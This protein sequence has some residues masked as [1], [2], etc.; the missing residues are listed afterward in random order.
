ME[1]LASHPASSQRDACRRR[2]SHC[3]AA[4]ALWA[5][6]G[7]ASAGPTIAF[8][9]EGFVTFGYAFQLWAREQSFTSSTDNGRATDIYFRRNRLLFSGQ[10]SDIYGFYVQLEAGNDDR[11]G[12]T[13]KPVFYRDAYITADYSDALRF[14]A[15]RFKSTFSR[16]NLEACLEPLTADRAEVISYAPFGAQGGTRD[17]GFALWGNLADAKVQYRLM[18][19]DGRQ[20]DEVARKSLRVTA[21]AHVSLLDPEADYGYKATY[22]GTRRVLTLGAAVDYQ[23]KVAYA[24]FPARTDAKDY[25]AWTVDAF[26][27]YPTTAGTFTLSAALFDYSTGNAINQA[28][29]PLLPV[30]SELKAAYLKGAYLFPQRVGPGRLQPFFRYEKSAYAVTGGLFDQQW[31]SAGLNYYLNGQNLKLMLEHASIRFDTQHPT[32]PT[33]RDYNHTTLGLQF[34]F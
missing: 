3:A 12:N 16:E 18:L 6:A 27:E 10:A 15:G 17:T 24:N 30:S 9:D 32:N 21:R 4:L 19:A 31:R 26:L 28:P 20:G 13:D 8:G 33:L 25:K 5:V 34:I 11:N 14:I 1:R 7:T 2:H 22:V 23:A 29:D